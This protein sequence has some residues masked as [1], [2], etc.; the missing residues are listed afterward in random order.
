MKNAKG[1]AVLL[2]VLF[3]G[4]LLG[5][6]GTVFYY[7]SQFSAKVGERPQHRHSPREMAE[8]L[9]RILGLS[10]EQ[11]D[12]AEAVIASHEPEVQA[13]HAK[14]KAAMDRILDQ[15]SLELAP[16]LTPEQN[17]RLA[18]FVIDI[19]SRPFPPRRGNE[20]DLGGGKGGRD[21]HD[22]P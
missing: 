20:P 11:V 10:P 5:A 15:V 18:E 21:K 9:G 17:A 4:V 13:L 6:S 22:Q 12:T 7:E 14:G 2:V 3:A 19:K 16:H 8:R 1:I